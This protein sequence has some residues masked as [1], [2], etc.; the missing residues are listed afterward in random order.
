MPARALYA[1]SEEMIPERNQ[2]RSGHGANCVNNRSRQM[3]VS[4][5]FSHRLI[6]QLRRVAVHVIRQQRERAG[7]VAARHR[8]RIR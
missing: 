7:H 3:P 6:R 1:Y 4:H 5:V 2:R 8:G